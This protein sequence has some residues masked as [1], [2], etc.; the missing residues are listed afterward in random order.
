MIMMML[1]LMRMMLLLLVVVTQDSVLRRCGDGRRRGKTQ[2]R[3]HYVLGNSDWSS[4]VLWD[5]DGI[6]GKNN[7]LR[8]RRSRRSRW[9]SCRSSK[10]MTSRRL[11]KGAVFFLRPTDGPN[12][13]IFSSPHRDAICANFES[14]GPTK[15]LRDQ[16][17]IVCPYLNSAKC[18]DDG[19][20]NVAV[21]V[22]AFTHEIIFGQIRR[23]KVML[24]L[25][26]DHVFQII[27]ASRVVVIW[28][29]RLAGVNGCGGAAGCSNGIHGRSATR[30]RRSFAAA[31]AAIEF[32][33]EGAP[34]GTLGR[35][36]G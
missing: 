30:R 4:C 22:H 16:K 13:G 19:N 3:R 2:R 27:S 34:I 33:S 29:K 32:G 15:S 1:L 28:I 11:M 5:G 10:R 36:A 8:R 20:G 12:G 17:N 14:R 24:N 9:S 31:S 6:N 7:G 35:G 26:S 25:H 21:G 23:R 18:G